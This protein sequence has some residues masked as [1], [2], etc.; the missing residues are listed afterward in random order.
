[1]DST[2]SDGAIYGMAQKF[3]AD[4]SRRAVMSQANSF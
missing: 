4:L 1:M 3:V 2:L